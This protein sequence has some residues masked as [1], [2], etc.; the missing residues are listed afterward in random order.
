ML[1]DYVCDIGKYRPNLI[2]YFQDFL[3]EL[4]QLYS[5]M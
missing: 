4:S 1:H 3:L 5:L 2:A